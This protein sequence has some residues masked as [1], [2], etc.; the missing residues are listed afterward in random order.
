VTV[1][2]G[3]G[4]GETRAVGTIGVVSG[5]DTWTASEDAGVAVGGSVAG[6]VALGCAGRAEALG[7]GVVVLGAGVVVG[8]GLTCTGVVVVVVAGSVRTCDADVLGEP[9]AS[10]W[11]PVGIGSTA[12]VLRS[13]A[14]GS[15]DA[16]GTSAQAQIR[17]SE[18][19]QRCLARSPRPRRSDATQMLNPVPPSLAVCCEKAN[20]PNA[21]VK[22]L[23]WD[24]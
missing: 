7:V 11:R 19:L 14:G 16:T 3:G 4:G 10:G 9:N 1:G 24:E 8:V 5:A 20:C 23:P 18:S 2:A 15:A 12:A 6:G 21:V 22:P 17:A 13:G